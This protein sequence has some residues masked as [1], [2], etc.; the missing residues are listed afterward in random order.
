M[1]NENTTTNTDIR[2]SIDYAFEL[3]KKNVDMILST[4]PLIVREYT[5]YL[6]RSTGKMIR[7]QSL[8][9]CALDKDNLVHPDS[10]S[11]GSAIEILHLATLVHDDVIDNADLRRGKPSLQKKHGKRTAVICGDYLL[12]VAL[13][14]AASVSDKNDY[15]NRTL[16]DYMSKV[17]LGELGQHINNGNFN[18]TVYRYLKIISGK[19]AALFEAAFHSGSIIM[20]KDVSHEVLREYSK[21][22]RYLGMIFQLTDDC[23]DFESTENVALKP[24]QSDFE[25]NVITLPLIHA[26]SKRSEL[27]ESAI[28]G[29]LTRKDINQ[30]VEST[31]GILY[32]RVMAKKYYDKSM[33]IIKSLDASPEKKSLLHDL[34]EKAYRVF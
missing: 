27:K 23:M 31:G 4:S 5:Q 15:K 13:K 19:T 16:P 10:I 26:F 25:Q 22:G 7:A 28:K 32:T 18:L 34:L 20:D 3:L 11:F 2:I 17:C 24:V 6:A 8:L 14:T 9:T 21:L 1:T 30:V 33:N 12:C 29:N